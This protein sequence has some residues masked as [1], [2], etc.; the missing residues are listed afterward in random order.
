M[1]QVPAWTEDG[2]DHPAAVEVRGLGITESF[3]DTESAPITAVVLDGRGYAG[4]LTVSFTGG[5]APVEG[6]TPVAFTKKAVIP[7]LMP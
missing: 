1:R 7:R 2:V 5:S 3:P 6:A 4:A